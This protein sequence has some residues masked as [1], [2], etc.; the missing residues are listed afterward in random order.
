MEAKNPALI[1]IGETVLALVK[2]LLYWPL[3]WYSSGFLNTLR[4]TGRR[5]VGTWKS[6]ALG[7]W[8]AN[9]FRPMYGQYDFAS[10]IISFFMRLVQVI[11]RMIIMVIMTV[12]ILLIPIIYLA[13]PVVTV[14][15]L[16]IN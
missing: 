16:I 3:W 1:K 4:G 15:Q 5:I 8:L 10:R 11:F 9:I 6:L 2:H 14:W 13:L 7:I 12:L